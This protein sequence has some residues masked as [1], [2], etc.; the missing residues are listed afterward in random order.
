MC[1]GRRVGREKV[2]Q[3]GFLGEMENALRSR[4]SIV[5][6]LCRYKYGARVR[7]QKC[8]N[9]NPNEKEKEKNPHIGSPNSDDR[10][11]DRKLGR[12]M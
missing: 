1:G 5:L 3:G 12:K 6:G 7:R 11:A 4:S 10:W 8:R 2:G 9:E